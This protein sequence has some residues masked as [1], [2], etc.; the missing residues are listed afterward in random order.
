MTRVLWKPELLVPDNFTP[1]TRT[2]WGGRRLIERC[3]AGLGVRDPGGAVGESW[4][5]SVEPSFPSR[6]VGRD[7]TLAARIAADPVAWLGAREA[8]ARGQLSL[9]V[10]L[11]D[12]SADLSVQVHPDVDD[13]ALEPDEAGK[14]EAWVILDAAPGAGIYLGFR[15]GVDRGAVERCLGDS[16]PMDELMN[17]VPVEPGDVFQLPTGTPHAIGAGVALYEAQRVEPGR[18]GVTYRFWDW[19][20]R[21]DAQGQLDPK[22]GRPR[23]LHVERSIAVTRWDAPRG[24]ALV[25]ALRA[26]PRPVR[27]PVARRV[28]V[29]WEWFWVE[30]WRG[31]GDLG[32]PGADTLLALTCVEGRARVQSED[33]AVVLPKGQSAVVPARAGDL[34]VRCE[35]ARVLVTR[36][37][38]EAP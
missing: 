14:P 2:P 6:L 11:L 29:R 22:G 38:T 12:A 31:T 10:K 33:G 27:A 34:A 25:E 24:Q 21:F 30:E 1:P 17:F 9:L 13:P 26:N 8:R 7:E 32:V 37:P 5:V 23:P 19:G 4:E 16:G 36:L 20:R 18:R 3:K 15:E 28:L 35:R